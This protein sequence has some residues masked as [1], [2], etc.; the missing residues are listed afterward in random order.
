MKQNSFSSKEY[1]LQDGIKN[2]FPNLLLREIL[3]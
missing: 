1:L 2:R 3:K